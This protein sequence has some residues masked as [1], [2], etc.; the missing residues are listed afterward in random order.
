MT[1][2]SFSCDAV[3]FDLDGTLIDT[4]PD[5]VTVVNEQRR[6]HNLP[7]LGAPAISSQVSNGSRALIELSF[8]LSADDD[9]FEKYRQELLDL[10]LEI[11][12]REA[13]LYP[14][15]NDVLRKLEQQNIPWG[16]VTNKPRIYSEKLLSRMELSERCDV[17]VCPC[18]LAKA[19][20]DP[21]GIL[22][23]MRKLNARPEYTVYVGDHERDIQAAKAAGELTS[24]S[25]SYGYLKDPKEAYRWGADFTATS[26]KEIIEIMEKA[27]SKN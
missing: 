8:G 15:M 17:L 27:F 26:A 14:Q 12:G 6:I 21:E 11:V 9:N 22:L 16:I 24:I 1:T 4:A 23:A 25:V 7:E 2:N 13:T 3:L 20:P 10:Y 5:F 18:D 19:K